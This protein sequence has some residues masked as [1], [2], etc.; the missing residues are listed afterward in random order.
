MDEIDQPP[1]FVIQDASRCPYPIVEGP[2]WLTVFASND[3]TS[4]RW[5]R[6]ERHYINGW[7][8]GA[9]SLGYITERY[10]RW[11]FTPRKRGLQ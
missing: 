1:G 8:P 9:R 3:L 11:R 4:K 5:R 10:V 7:M 6:V 2:G